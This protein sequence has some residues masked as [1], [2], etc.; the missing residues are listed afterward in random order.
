MQLLVGHAKLRGWYGAQGSQGPGW[1]KSRSHRRLSLGRERCVGHGNASRGA[2][3]GP[4][5]VKDAG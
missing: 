2:G 5:V 1:V 4:R 3:G